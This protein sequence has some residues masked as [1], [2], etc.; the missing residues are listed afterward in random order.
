MTRWTRLLLVCLVPLASCK[1][2]VTLIELD[3]PGRGTY[4]VGSTNME[5]ADAY[6]DIGDEAMGHILSGDTI[7]APDGL[8]VSG[9][10]KH[11]ESA[12]I[13]DVDVPDDPGTYGTVAGKSLPVS[14]FVTWPTETADEPN[15]YAF[16]YQDAQFGVFEDMLAPG[17]SPVFA[18]EAAQDPLVIL[19]HGWSAHGIYDVGHAHSLSRHGYIVAVLFFGDLRERPEEDTGQ[20]AFL[21]PLFTRAALDAVL[22]SE[23]FGARIDTDNIG[24][25]GHSFG[26][27]TAL[28]LNGGQHRDNPATVH[29]PRISASVIAAP[30]VG[31]RNGFRTHHAFGDGNETL[32]RVTVPV[33]SFV[34]SN[35]EVTTPA[36]IYPAMKQLSGPTYVIELIDQPHVFDGGSWEDRD[37]WELIFFNAYLKGDDAALEAMRSGGSMRGGNEDV[38]HFDYQQLP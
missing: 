24:I 28:A 29:D 36:T 23:A 4:A 37:N 33:L 34:A 26:G 2:D 6:A 38:Q 17:E 12:W 21:R 35:D 18:D 22:E 13:V 19:A 3:P 9:I 31:N 14:L 25:S 30:W 27:F 1:E 20:A 7:Q 15:E 10:M 8:Y 5:V 11:P 32:Q 16:P